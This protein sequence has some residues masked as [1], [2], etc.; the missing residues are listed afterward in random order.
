[1]LYRVPLATLGAQAELTDSLGML[2]A[3][4]QIDVIPQT[5]P[6]YANKPSLKH[7]VTRDMI[8]PLGQ[9]I[10]NHPAELKV[11]Y[12]DPFTFNLL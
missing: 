8:G 9:V 2:N 3:H 12:K 5:L 1:M 7:A 6:L 11:V 4:Q 10:H